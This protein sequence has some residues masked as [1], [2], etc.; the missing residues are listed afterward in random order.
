MEPLGS[1]KRPVI[2][3]VNNEEKATRVAEI[4]KNMGFNLFSDLNMMRI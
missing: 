2:V 4:V 3:K 1:K